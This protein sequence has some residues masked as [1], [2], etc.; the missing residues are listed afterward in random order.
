MPA[1]SKQREQIPNEGKTLEDAYIGGMSVSTRERE[2]KRDA[3]TDNR[4]A[5]AQVEGA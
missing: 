5:Q 3:P 2:M 4:P 1:T